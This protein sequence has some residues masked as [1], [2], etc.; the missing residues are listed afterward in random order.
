[1]GS[2]FLQMVLKSKLSSAEADS[3]EV[4]VPAGILA[5]DYP[6][7]PLAGEFFAP[8]SAFRRPAFRCIFFPVN[9]SPVIFSPANLSPA[10]MF[11]LPV[12]AAPVPLRPVS[13][14]LIPFFPILRR[15]ISFLPVL[16][17]PVQFHP[18]LCRRISSL[19]VPLTLLLPPC[20][21]FPASPRQFPARRTFLRSSGSPSESIPFWSCSLSTGPITACSK[22]SPRA[23]SGG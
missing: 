4:F 22:L 6:A 1:M 12:L 14:R 3:A 19:Q 18:V 21:R 11:W 13:C 23:A 5:P 8:R 9:L 7:N 2:K 16:L 15:R 20:P 10:P 17:C